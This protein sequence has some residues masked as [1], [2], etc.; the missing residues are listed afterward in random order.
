MG[1]LER[2]SSGK[3]RRRWRALRV[4]LPGA[5]RLLRVAFGFGC[6]VILVRNLAGSRQSAFER[7][8]Q[9]TSP[10]AAK[11]RRVGDTRRAR[12]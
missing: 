4:W 7:L 10:S 3:R 12:R 9:K 5:G 11:P 1:L 6:L 8:C 2:P